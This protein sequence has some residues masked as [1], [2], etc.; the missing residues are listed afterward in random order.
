MRRTLNVLVSRRPTIALT[1]RRCRRQP[2][3]HERCGAAINPIAP[4]PNRRVTACKE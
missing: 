1:R 4:S 2:S 3:Q